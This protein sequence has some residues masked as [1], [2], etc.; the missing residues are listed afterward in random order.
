MNKISVLFLA[1][2]AL[3]VTA[4]CND[5]A[6]NPY[7]KDAQVTVINSNM[8]LDAIASAGVITFSANGAATASC[9]QSWCTVNVEN[10][11]TVRL[12]STQNNGRESRSTLVVIRCNGDSVQVP[13]VQRG[14][15]LI[16]SELSM[17][18]ISNDEQKMECHFTT[19][20]PLTLTSAPEWVTATLSQETGKLE[21]AFTA[22]T[23]GDYRRGWVKVQAGEFKDSIEVLQ[24][25]FDQQ[26][27]GNYYLKYKDKNGMAKSLPVTV[28]KTGI[29]LSAFKM[30]FPVTF[31]AEQMSIV[32]KSG[33]KI[34]SRDN[35]NFYNIFYNDEENRW[36]AYSTQAAM[37]FVFGNEV[38]DATGDKVVRARFK[39]VRSDVVFDVLAVHTFTPDSLKESCDNGVFQSLKMF[40]PYLEKR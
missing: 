16:F 26:F 27:A 9:A 11:N 7:A 38:N 15:E 30:L 29:S 22:N 39:P 18:A 17:P 12:E 32:M 28:S 24:Y 1:V 2:A 25:D 33:Q 3:F 8:V 19:N 40:N 34:G 4:S 20:L 21:V 6:S 36:S 35:N 13:V 10:N 5:D 37:Q 14:A 23:T 31:N